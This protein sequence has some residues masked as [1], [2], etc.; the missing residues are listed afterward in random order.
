MFRETR[1]DSPARAGDRKVNRASLRQ[2]LL[3]VPISQYRK[4]LSLAET[5]SA[6]SQKR[7]IK[8]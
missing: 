8:R 1:T 4:F 3:K 2:P 5:Q 7:L 6:P